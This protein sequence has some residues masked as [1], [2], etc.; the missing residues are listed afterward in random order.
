MSMARRTWTVIGYAIGTIA[1][2]FACTY[3]GLLLFDRWVDAPR[4]STL[5][6][7]VVQSQRNGEN[8]CDFAVATADASTPCP[9]RLT[10]TRFSAT[11][12]TGWCGWPTTAR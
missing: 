10:S 3:A 12:W 5:R 6:E 7:A 1:I 8:L 9:S 11:P 4:Q 2:V